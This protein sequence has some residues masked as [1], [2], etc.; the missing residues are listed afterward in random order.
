[1]S[2]NLFL[3]DKKIPK[4]IWTDTKE[5]EYA[6]Y[7]WV[8]V[9]DYESFIETILE[10]G[11]PTRVSFDHD[12]DEEHSDIE[13]DKTIP[14]DSFKTKTGYDCALWLIEYCIDYSK[15]LPQTKVHSPRGKGKKNIETILESFSKYQKT[16]D[17]NTKSNKK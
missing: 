3:D 8:T 1:M 12:L 13:K 14:Y 7:N 10:K 16:L 5:P 6:V 15:N 9:K 2:Y 11:L 4:D 17:K